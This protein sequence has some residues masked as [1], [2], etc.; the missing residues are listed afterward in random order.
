M[1]LD[2]DGFIS[3]AEYTAALQRA[4]A[5]DATEESGKSVLR[6]YDTSKDGRLNY[7]EFKVL[8]Q[9][10]QQRRDQSDIVKIGFLYKMVGAGDVH[11]IKFLVTHQARPLTGP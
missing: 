2:G 4:G 8:A 6:K 10:M 9:E 3:V 1:D 7:E 11:S 5:K